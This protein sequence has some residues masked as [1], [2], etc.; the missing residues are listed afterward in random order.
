MLWKEL[1]PTELVLLIIYWYLF[2]PNYNQRK[3]EDTSKFSK[4]ERKGN[5]WKVNTGETEEEE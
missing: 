2:I 1:K 5:A 4:E 3:S